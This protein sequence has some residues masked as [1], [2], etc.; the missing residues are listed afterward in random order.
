MAAGALSRPPV[1][2]AL[3]IA[4]AIAAYLI[5]SDVVAFL[6]PHEFPIGVGMGLGIIIGLVLFTLVIRH[7]AKITI[8][9]M[10]AIAIILIVLGSI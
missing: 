1:M 7:S 10:V 5:A 4:G 3:I 9:I 8:P 6:E 2:L